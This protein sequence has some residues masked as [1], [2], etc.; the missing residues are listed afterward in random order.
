[1][2]Q[3]TPDYYQPPNMLLIEYL[4]LINKPSLAEHKTSGCK[5]TFK[6]TVFCLANTRNTILLQILQSKN[7]KSSNRIDLTL[8]LWGTIWCR[9]V[10]VMG[11][12]IF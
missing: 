9:E 6:V 2:I 5:R 4:P 11:H 1:M 8:I 3:L 10:A 7:E 12:F